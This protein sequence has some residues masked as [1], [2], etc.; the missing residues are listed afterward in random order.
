VGDRGIGHSIRA[1]VPAGRH[2]GA[3]GRGALPGRT[4]SIVLLGL[5][6]LLDPA[7]R[8]S[9]FLFR[10]PSRQELLPVAVALPVG[11]LL[12]AL[13]RF[14]VL[15]ALGADSAP[16][17]GQRSIVVFAVVGGVF[18][19]LVEE[20]LF[21]GLMLG[22]LVERGVPAYAAAG[23]PSPPSEPSTTTADPP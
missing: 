5:Y 20:V 19:P 16:G 8:R 7:T 3:R 23:A 14:A 2:R 21:R 22:Y 11:Y 9:L 4:G 17:S 15:T 18:A 12:A 10:R 13:A 6:V 1:D